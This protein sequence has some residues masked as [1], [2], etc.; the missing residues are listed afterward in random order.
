MLLPLAL[1]ITLAVD[2]PQ[3]RVWIEGTSNVARWSCRAERFAARVD[4]GRVSLQVAVRDL[5][6]GNR[7]M[8]HDL[9]A[10]LRASSPQSA[11]SIIAVF[12]IDDGQSG[13]SSGTLEV[14]GVKRTVRAEVTVE[15]AADGRLRARGAV[16]LLMTDFGVRPPTGLLGLIRARNE[17]VVR[18]ELVIADS[19]RPVGR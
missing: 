5:S 13:T 6:C 10:A 11:S 7:R 8:D 4:S 15:L 19:S 3:G 14:V 2:E 18:F 1:A 16:P 17:V 12:G 9:F